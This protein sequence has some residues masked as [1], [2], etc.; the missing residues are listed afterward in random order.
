MSEGQRFNPDM[1]RLARDA[2]KLTQA[3]LAAA[4]GVT[5]ALIS[6]LEHGLITKPSEEVVT[7]LSTALKFPPAFFRQLDRAI[8]FPHFHY[9][10]RARMGAKELAR[11]E[12]IINIRRQ[13]LLKLLRSYEQPIE[14]PIPKWIWMLPAPRQRGLPS[15]CAPIG[16]CREGRWKNLW[17]LWN[18][19]AELSFRPILKLQCWTE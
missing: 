12:A 6:K 19:L 2:K 4:S 11:I 15:A 10:R 3:D 17:K 8:G 13:H 1:L 18:T 14:K 16:Y 7:A 9:R 5:Q